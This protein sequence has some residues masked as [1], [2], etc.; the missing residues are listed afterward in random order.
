MQHSTRLRLDLGEVLLWTNWIEYASWRLS[1]TLPPEELLVLFVVQSLELAR[2]L[3][4][5]LDRRLPKEAVDGYI[6]GYLLDRVWSYHL[7]TDLVREDVRASG[8]RVAHIDSKLLLR[9]CRRMVALVMLQ[10]G[11]SAEDI[12]IRT[13]A[14]RA[15]LSGLKLSASKAHRSSQPPR[16]STPTSARI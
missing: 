2:S 16:P 7:V 5:V 14:R 10:P 15:V 12:G 9:T 11:I 3:N 1:F 4:S 8:S 13:T 6:R